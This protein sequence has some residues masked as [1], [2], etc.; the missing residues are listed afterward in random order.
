MPTGAVNVLATGWQPTV[1]FTSYINA[2]V[3]AVSATAYNPIVT[4]DASTP[5]SIVQRSKPTA[6]GS[7]LTTSIALANAFT[8]ASSTSNRLL[9]VIGI[10]YN[11]GTPVTLNITDNLGCTWTQL[12]VNQQANGGNNQ[13]LYVFTAPVASNGSL[14]LTVTASST[15]AANWNIGWSCMEVAGLDGSA[16]TGS[17]R[18]SATAPGNQGTLASTSV[19][20]GTTTSDVV[21]DLAIGIASI[22]NG[23]ALVVSAAGGNFALDAGLSNQG[24]P[25]LGLGVSTA[26]GAGIAESTSF[27]YASANVQDVGALAVVAGAPYPLVLV[28]AFQPTV[29]TGTGPVTALPSVAIVTAAGYNPTV[30][31]QATPQTANVGVGGLAPGWATTPQTSP[32]TVSGQPPLV[33]GSVTVIPLVAPVPVVGNDPVVGAVTGVAVGRANVTVVGL[34]PQ[35]VTG[36]VVGASVAVVAPSLV[37]MVGTVAQWANVTVTGYRV[38]I[39]VS[40][41]SIITVRA[42]TS[43]VVSVRASTQPLV[44]ADAG[45]E[46][47][48]DAETGTQVMVDANAGTKTL[49]TVGAGTEAEN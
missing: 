10:N 33:S 34:G 4:V 48:T 35:P 3:G 21:G 20:C 23:H 44:D 38:Y 39:P 29:S 17:L 32:V 8:I 9:L 26:L 5:W 18:T 27:T 31:V 6:T 25:H 49:V 40:V 30:T 2:D 14:V 16:G 46:L 13:Y 15:V 1:T 22:R 41:P 42:D 11:N 12:L 24:D 43:L 7:S 19:S 36:A 47:L 45:T 37:P 28:G